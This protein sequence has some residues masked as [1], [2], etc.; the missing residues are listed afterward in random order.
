MSSAS[1]STTSLVSYTT[2]TSRT[3]VNAAQPKDFQAAFA[4]LQSTYGSS[5]TAPT[6]VQ[7]KKTTAPSAPAVSARVPTT[8]APDQQKDN[9]AAFAGLSGESSY[10]LAGRAPVPV[11]KSQK[12]SSTSLFSKLTR[13][14]T[15]AS[16]LSTSP[17]DKKVAPIP[18]PPRT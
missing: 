7:K 10:G 9:Q 16:A 17:T 4:Q 2:A 1:S 12:H 3:P 15:K 8:P 14:S 18:H 13:T 5:A 11:Q 6:P